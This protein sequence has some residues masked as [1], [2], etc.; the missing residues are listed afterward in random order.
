MCS[1]IAWTRA[2]GA[3]VGWQIR[4]PADYPSVRYITRDIDPFDAELV[5]DE[6]FWSEGEKDIDSLNN[7]DLPAFTFGG[8]GNGLPD[9]IAGVFEGSEDRCFSRQ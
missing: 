8:V 2:N 1:G 4:K 5:A 6:I 3:P 9:D 7:V